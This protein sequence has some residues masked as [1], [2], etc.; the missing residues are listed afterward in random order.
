MYP[1]SQS[2]VETRT[3]SSNCAGTDS[4]YKKTCKHCDVI[5]SGMHYWKISPFAQ[6]FVRGSKYDFLPR[7]RKVHR[8]CATYQ[9]VP[10][11]RKPFNVHKSPSESVH[12]I[13]RWGCCPW[14]N[15]ELFAFSILNRSSPKTSK[16]SIVV[17]A[18]LR[19]KDVPLLL[20]CKLSCSLGQ[21]NNINRSVNEEEDVG[22]R[23]NC[24][25]ELQ[26]GW[27]KL[28]NTWNKSHV[29]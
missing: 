9:V 22:W 29:Y 18:I 20:T 15:G 7:K 4:W 6:S 11:K 10:A 26:H 25:H 16:I 24:R 14:R 5:N 17:H 21:R 3:F 12:R 8:Y 28:N 27:C 23:R 13:F 2:G 1:R 19:G